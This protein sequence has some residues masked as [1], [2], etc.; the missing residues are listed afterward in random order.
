MTDEAKE[1]LASG[2]DASAPSDVTK[3]PSTPSCRC[4]IILIVCAQLYFGG[5][6]YAFERMR[7]NDTDCAHSPG[8]GHVRTLTPDY[9]YAEIFRIAPF[10]F[11]DSIREGRSL[12]FPMSFA[13]PPKSPIRYGVWFKMVRANTSGIF[14]N[15]QRS[16]RVETREEVERRYGR[17]DRT[18]C[19]HVHALGYS[20]LQ[21]RVRRSPPWSE[22]I[23]CD[24]AHDRVASVGACTPALHRLDDDNNWRACECS[25]VANVVNCGVAPPQGDCCDAKRALYAA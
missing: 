6:L 25:D 15:V 18:W 12:G 20:S 11:A 2:S 13:P 23:M 7:R 21:I 9:E 14:I 17:D 16:L 10:C 3:A 5:F 22:L 24:D 19:T 8:G 4:A 1:K